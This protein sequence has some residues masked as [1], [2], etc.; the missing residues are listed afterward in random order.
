[1]LKSGGVELMDCPE[2]GSSLNKS[3]GGSGSN[4]G[5]LPAKLGGSAGKPS[6]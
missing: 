5:A 4:S 1:M 2:S 3:I 6:L